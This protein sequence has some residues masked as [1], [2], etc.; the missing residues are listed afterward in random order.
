[1]GDKRDIIKEVD[2]GQENFEE[3]KIVASGL[4]HSLAYLTSKEGSRTF[5]WGHKVGFDQGEDPV[6][7]LELRGKEIVKLTAGRAHSCVLTKSGEV[8]VWGSG[9]EGRLGIGHRKD[10]IEPVSLEFEDNL[11]VLDV[12]CG[13]DHTLVLVDG[14]VSDYS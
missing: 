7:L 10:Q 13:Y 14:E 5:Q 6:E 4:S 2:I 8:Y 12:A 9:R 3:F 11:K 1:M